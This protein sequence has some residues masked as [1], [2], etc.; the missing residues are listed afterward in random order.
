M[1]IS[2]EIIDRTL[3]SLQGTQGYAACEQLLDAGFEAWW[4]GGCVRDMA[5]G[6]LPEDIDIATNATPEDIIKIFAKY[7]DRSAALGAVVVSLEGQSPEI[8]TF[9]EEH[10]LSDGRFPESVT[11][12]DRKSDAARR[13][14]TINAMYW[15]P[16]SSE[17]FDPYNGEMDLQESLVRFIGDPKM[18]IEHDALRL[19]RIVRFRA[20]INGQYHP[21]T[22]TALHHCAKSVSVLSGE[23]RY[24]ELE[25]ILLGPHPDL[26]FQDLWESDV[27]ETLIPQ[28]HACKGVAQPTSAHKE[29]DVWEHTLDV[30]QSFTEDH[31]ADTRWAAL[32]HDIGKVQTFSIDDER[33]RF[34]E[35]AKIG[36]EIS[37]DVLDALKLPSK[38]RDKICWIIE[39]HMMMGTFAELNVSRKHHWYYHPWFIELLQVF[40]LDIAGT[41]PSNFD[42]YDSIIQ[43]YNTFL[44]ENPRPQKPLL[45]GEDVMETL[46]IEAGMKVGEALQALSEAQKKKEIT[47]KQE[48]LEFLQQ[49]DV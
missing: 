34:N 19:L 11:F 44:D 4:V 35:H 32:L 21:D 10:E 17:L 9:R 2:Q 15:N 14:I 45:S 12:T 24:R 41:T 38:R 40:W 36:A 23:R 31:G 46:G 47:T 43:D 39:H 30:L 25:K 1:P 16:I 29:G 8:T 7:D 6:V 20:L 33:I 13:D 27:L 42:L 48:A 37:K 22:F 28:L 49:L 26:A 5:R 3:S 18:R